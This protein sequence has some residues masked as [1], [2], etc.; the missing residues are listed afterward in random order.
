MLA[1]AKERLD[2]A[3]RPAVSPLTAEEL[4]GGAPRLNAGIDILAPSV[5]VR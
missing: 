5:T 4:A 3:A 2:G 1:V